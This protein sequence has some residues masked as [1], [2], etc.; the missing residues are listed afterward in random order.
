MERAVSLIQ[1]NFRMRKSFASIKKVIEVPNLIDIQ[2]RSYEIFLRP[3][4]AAIKAQ[5]EAAATEWE[6]TQR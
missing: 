3:V 1:D 5:G 6:Q 2:K 4:P